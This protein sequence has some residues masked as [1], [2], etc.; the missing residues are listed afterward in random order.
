MIIVVSN[1]FKL[2]KFHGMVIYRQH[3]PLQ[4]TLEQ[5]CSVMHNNFTNSQLYQWFIC[6]E[7]KKKHESCLSKVEKLIVRKLVMGCGTLH[8]V[9][10]KRS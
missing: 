5:V 6:E 1:T 7:V 2:E 9:I 3:N 8:E 10:R 4:F